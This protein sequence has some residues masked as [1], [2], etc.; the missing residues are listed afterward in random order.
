MNAVND[1][2]NGKLTSLQA[3]RAYN[4]PHTTVRRYR[5]KILKPKTTKV[6]NM[7]SDKNLLNAYPNE[8]LQTAVAQILKGDATTEE[9]SEKFKIPILTLKENVDNV[10]QSG[11]LPIKKEQ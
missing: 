8:D 1:I 9:A 3:S 5:D 6:A 2:L 10:M 11:I 4:V 7:P